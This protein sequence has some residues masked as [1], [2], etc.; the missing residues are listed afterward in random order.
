MKSKM[1]FKLKKQT[2]LTALKAIVWVT[3]PLLTAN[4]YTEKTKTYLSN[5][6]AVI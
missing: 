2:Q 1:I 6:Q 4:D 5:K 3:H